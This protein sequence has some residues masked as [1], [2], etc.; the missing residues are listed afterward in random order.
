[1]QKKF[2]IRDREVSLDI[3]ADSGW[4][5]RGEGA[6]TVSVDDREQTIEVLESGQHHL[7]IVIDGRRHVL[8]VAPGEEAGEL[9]IGVGGRARRVRE[10]VEQRRARRGGPGGG[11][12]QTMVTPSF[13]A[14][15]VK[16]LV[17]VGELV[18]KEQPLV[19]VSAMKMEMTLVSPRDGVVRA[20]NTAEGLAVSPGD[21]LVVVEE[22]EAGETERSSDDG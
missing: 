15:V 22:A 21:E 7:D 1:M 19:V 18:E 13:P 11:E 20:V 9:W 3:P 14:T 17:E 8:T 12:A 10:V 16:V 4:S 6:V 2:L 5:V